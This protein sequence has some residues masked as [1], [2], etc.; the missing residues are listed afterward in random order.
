MRPAGRLQAAIE[1]LSEIR[2]RH[3]P[4]SQALAEWGRAHRFAGSGDRAAIG[5]LVYDAQRRK[6][7]IA[8]RMGDESPR[9]LALG[10]MVVAWGESAEAVD[11]LCDG[12]K[13]APGP[14][15]DAERE[16]LAGTLAEEAPPWL[17]GDYPEWLHASLERV[18]GERAVQE[19]AGLA[20]RAPVDMRVNTLKADRDKVLKSLTKFSPEKAR[21]SPVGLRIPPPV[22]PGRSP[23]LEAD[24]SHGKGWFE[25]QDEG[26]Q[27]AAL[28][29]GATP[30]RQLLDLCAGS[31]GKTLA[32]AAA[33]ENRG[34]IHAYDT[35]AMRLRPIFER[36]KRASARNV[37]VLRAGEEAALT[38][39]SGK[40]D[41]V[42][43]DAPCTGSG[44]WRR[45]PDAKWRLRPEALERRRR[46]QQEVLDQGAPLVKPGGRLVYVTCSVLPEEN[47]DQVA[48]FLER[49]PDFSILPFAEVWGE[50]IGGEPP[51]SADGRSDTL[52]LTPA[53]HGTDGFFIAI[54]Q[55]SGAAG[56]QQQ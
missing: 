16:G 50:A 1:V 44:V 40:M 56:G 37:Q 23:H 4:A 41:I 47:T 29:A 33:M 13:F 39:L 6:A 53:S 28:L 24:T 26:S 49:R 30:G 25:I 9:S 3:R 54:L 14:L 55:R 19:G 21:F 51:A 11:A 52:L 8:A 7:S 48:A 22:G 43:I 45:R 17:R 2:D 31:G 34:Q 36:L 20:R 35:D 46:E 10:A 12:S 5:N 38:A 42:V 15:S 18:F 27:I 32:L